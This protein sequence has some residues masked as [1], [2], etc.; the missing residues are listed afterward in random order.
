MSALNDFLTELRSSLHGRRRD[1]DDIIEEI[2]G[3][4]DDLVVAHLNSGASQHEAEKQALHEFGSVE[5]IASELQE[6]LAASA[7]RRT[8]LGVALVMVLQPLAWGYPFRLVSRGFEESSRASYQVLDQAVEW[9]G[10]AAIVLMML[11]WVASR[12]AMR[13]SASRQLVSRAVGITG[14]AAVSVVG[15]LGLGLSLTGPV[16]SGASPGV[17]MAWATAFLYLPL[18]AAGRVAWHAVRASHPPV[19]SPEG[20]A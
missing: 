2:G 3:G 9:A 6:V 11:G 16:G 12:W 18:V 10:T 15:I 19:T 13:H 20:S 14:L 17:V 8:A 1:I 4:L 7:S 5:T